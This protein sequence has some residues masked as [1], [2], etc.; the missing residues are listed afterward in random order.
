MGPRYLPKK[1]IFLKIEK[2]LIIILI[3]TKYLFYI[4][5]KHFISNNFLQTYHNY[6]NLIQITLI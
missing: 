6:I 2:Y 5:I 3:V 1:D 4:H